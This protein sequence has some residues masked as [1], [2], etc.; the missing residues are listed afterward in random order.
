MLTGI[1]DG[2]GRSGATSIPEPAIARVKLAI[3]M[4]CVVE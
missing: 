1:L 4:G 3:A 2:K